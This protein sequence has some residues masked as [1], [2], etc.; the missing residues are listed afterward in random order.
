MTKAAWGL[1][2][3]AQ[4]AFPEGVE[5]ALASAKA[6]LADSIVA[7]EKVTAEFAS[8]EHLKNR[9]L[10]PIRRSTFGFCHGLRG[11]VS[12]SSTCSD[13]FHLRFGEKRALQT[14]TRV[15]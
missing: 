7:K 12:T 4:T 2:L 15:D 10:E 3:L 13:A 6:A 5:A 1:H 11:A 14:V 8:L 9:T